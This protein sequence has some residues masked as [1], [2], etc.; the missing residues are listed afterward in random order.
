MIESHE[1]VARMLDHD[2]HG[3]IAITLRSAIARSSRS[4]ILVGLACLTKVLEFL[5][6]LG[7]RRLEDC[8]RVGDVLLGMARHD[9]HADAGSACRNRRR[10]HEV[11]DH[12]ELG[13]SA[14][15]EASETLRT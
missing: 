1:L 13:Q 12:S 6:S 8:D 14:T 4:N 3:E 2:E 11:G 5:L 15:D 9:L 7:F 10:F